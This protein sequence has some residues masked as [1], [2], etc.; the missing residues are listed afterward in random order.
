ME[1]YFYQYVVNESAYEAALEALGDEIHDGRIAEISVPMFKNYGM[2]LHDL[3]GVLERRKSP[4][5]SEQKIEQ[6]DGE[7]I[8]TLYIAHP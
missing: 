6:K 7:V 5:D 3:V 8:G 4:I 2:V 1:K